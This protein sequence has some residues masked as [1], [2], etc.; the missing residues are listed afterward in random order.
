[1]YLITFCFI[2]EIYDLGK[3]LFYFNLTEIRLIYTSTFSDEPKTSVKLQILTKENICAVHM[4]TVDGA[5]GS[6]NITHVV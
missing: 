1:M 4:E 6:S 2:L 3:S 5:V